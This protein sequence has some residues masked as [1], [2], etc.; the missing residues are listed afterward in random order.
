MRSARPRPVLYVDNAGAVELAKHKKSCNRSR[1]V[2]RRY[3]KVREL[4]A[5]G[6]IEV[7]FVGTKDN[8]SDILSKGTFEAAQFD[9]LRLRL[10]NGATPR[11]RAAIEG[12]EQPPKAPAKAVGGGVACVATA[13]SDASVGRS[14]RIVLGGVASEMTLPRV[15][16]E[17]RAAARAEGRAALVC[18]RAEVAALGGRRA[19]VMEAMA[20][21]EKSAE[22]AAGAP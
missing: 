11:R 17:E 2:Q 22:S 21:A 12:G 4:V 10:M 15:P 5:E 13:G 18:A 6:E 16:E 7:R 9:E 14:R 3:F 19:A 8:L 20:E 1:H